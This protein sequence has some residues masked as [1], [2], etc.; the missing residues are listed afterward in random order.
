MFPPGKSWFS[1]LYALYF[2]RLVPWIGGLL[3]HDRG[4]YSYLAKSVENFYPPERVAEL[5]QEAGFRRVSIKRFLNGAVC[6][7]VA[8][9]PHT[10]P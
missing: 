4:A 1:T 6:M 2:Y 9:K 3:A 5:L 10:S 7:H 8:E